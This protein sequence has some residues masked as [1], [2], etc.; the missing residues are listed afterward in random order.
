MRDFKDTLEWYRTHNTAREIGFNPDGM[1]LKVCRTDRDIGPLHLTAK[2]A[3]DLTP[4]GERI[5]NV[6]KLRRTMVLFYDDPDDSNR[7][8]HIATLIG[9]VKG[10]DPDSLH[11]LLVETN[12]VKAGELTVVR[13]D[14]FTE[15]WGDEFVFGAT[16]LNGEILDVPGQL[17]K[18]ERFNN[19]G[20]VYNLN[21]LHK[22]SMAGRERPRQ[23]LS[24]IETQIRR[25]PDSPKLPR[26]REFKDEWRDTR[27]IDMFLLDAAVKDGR[28]GV[29]KKVRDEI[30]RLIEK[31][32]DE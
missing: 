19:G 23:I 28:T 29:V 22:A 26:V 3:Q 24:Q 15:H 32:P 17:S 9:R 12:S 6:R 8:G 1:C 31:L 11:D 13:G 2:E 10:F 25:L 21:L 5:F 20:P 27:K 30:K 16:W 4:I 18:V 7:A 14:Y